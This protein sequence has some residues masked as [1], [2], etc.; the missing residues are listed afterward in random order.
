MISCREK[1]GSSVTVSI[2]TPLATPKLVL[3]IDFC[4]GGVRGAPDKAFD[5]ACV[6]RYLES[7]S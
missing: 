5:K 3:D 1:S 4:H 2:R 7:D 6:R